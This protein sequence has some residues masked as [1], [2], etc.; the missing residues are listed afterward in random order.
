LRRP[1]AAKEVHDE[2][3]NLRVQDGWRLKVFS[4]GGGAREHKNAGANDGSNAQG[5]QRPWP[6]RLLQTASGIFRFGNQLVDRLATEKLA[7]R[8]SDNIIRWRLS[9][10]WWLCQKVV[11]LLTRLWAA[12]T[13]Q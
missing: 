5:G 12:S 7:R 3:E 8:G 6:K 1:S 4:G 11:R 10:S 13:W 2:I 9:R